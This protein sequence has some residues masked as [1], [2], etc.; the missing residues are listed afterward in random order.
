MALSPGVYWT[1]CSRSRRCVS[2]AFSGASAGA[3]N[4]AVLVD[5]HADNGADGARATAQIAPNTLDATG[6]AKQLRGFR[7]RTRKV[8]APAT[9]FISSAHSNRAVRGLD[10]VAAV[11]L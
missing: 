5:G 10:L 6:S 11:V 1:A 7:W 4:A 3:M 8:Q 9:D 2:T